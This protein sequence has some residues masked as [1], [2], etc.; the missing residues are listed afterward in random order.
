MN[1]DLTEA[2]KRFASIKPCEDRRATP[3]H[4][5]G[6][7][8]AG[9]MVE[10]LKL[11]EGKV[12]ADLFPLCSFASCIQDSQGLHFQSEESESG[13][14]R[15]KLCPCGEANKRLLTLRA[16]GLPE[17]A[18]TKNHLN[19]DFSLEPGLKEKCNHWLEALARGEKRVLL[20]NGP[21]GTGKTHLLYLL[22]YLA[23]LSVNRR[24]TYLTQPH[25]LRARRKKMDD[26]SVELRTTAGSRAVFIDEL[27]YGRQTEWERSEMNSLIHEA[28]EKNQSLAIASDLPWD[29]L[30]RFLD[31]RI[32][33]R[34]I[35]GT[36]KKRLVHF[37][38]GPSKRSEG[39]DW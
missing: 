3:P 34:L 26:R 28:W 24:I 39:V 18:L 7:I 5:G 4:Q 16:I 29:D 31:R 25:W 19:Y 11:I 35:A 14:E 37:F 8:L 10:R 17:E 32:R 27:G 15:A 22:S 21:P 1:I 6:P 9:K 13:Y 12:S 36:E 33:D 38:H 20:L 2:L 30:G 23:A